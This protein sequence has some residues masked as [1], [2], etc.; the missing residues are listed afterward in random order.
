MIRNGGDREGSFN[1][2]NETLR[3]YLGVLIF[4]K[5]FITFVKSYPRIIC[6]PVV[7]KRE[8]GMG[9]FDISISESGTLMIDDI[10][11]ITPR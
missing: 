4:H 2:L 8:Q 9:L 10:S 3:N 6:S 5:I 11:N 1:V 7:S